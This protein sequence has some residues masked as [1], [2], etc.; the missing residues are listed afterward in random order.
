MSARSY[1]SEYST[2]TRYSYTNS[3]PGIDNG[4]LRGEVNKRYEASRSAPKA[5]GGNYNRVL[6]ARM[7]KLTRHQVRV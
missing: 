1:N 3:E 5:S 7:L 6:A 4:R 2:G